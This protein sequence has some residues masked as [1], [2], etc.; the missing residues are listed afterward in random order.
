MSKYEKSKIYKIVSN[1]NSELVYYGSTYTTLSRRLSNHK[2]KYKSYLK[3]KYPYTSS[4]ELLELEH[5]EIVLV[6][7]YPCDNV[8][9]LRKRERF[10]IENNNCVNKN[11]PSRTKKEW[12]EDNKEHNKEYFKE[13]YKD[14]EESIVAYKKQWRKLNKE[15]LKIQKKEYRELNKQKIKERKSMKFTCECGRELTIQSKARHKRTNYHRERSQ[16]I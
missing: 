6:E 9:E 10:Y 2:G 11:I 8:E 16:S 3:G 7:A 14:N 12:N 1:C 15:K 4:F 13:Y 5:F